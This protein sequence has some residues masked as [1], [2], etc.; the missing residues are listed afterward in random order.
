MAFGWLFACL[1]NCISTNIDR[2][3]EFFLFFNQK[4]ALVE[5]LA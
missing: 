3:F 4:I 1:S 5:G 2:H